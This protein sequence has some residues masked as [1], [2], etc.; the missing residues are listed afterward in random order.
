MNKLS[1]QKYQSPLIGVVGS[2][3]LGSPDFIDFIKDKYLSGKKADRDLPALKELSEKASMSDI[4][5]EVESVFE[6][7]QQLAKNIKLYLCK[8]YTQEK[9]KD[10]G[11]HFGIGESGV[12]QACRRFAQKIDRD[13]KL[14]RKIER[15]EKKLNLATKKGG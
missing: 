7:E 13:K 4:I 8:R 9:L 6:K 15:I 10:L 12:S 1:D 2:T 5:N 14:K 11:K 3:I